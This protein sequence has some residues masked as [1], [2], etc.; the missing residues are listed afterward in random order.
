MVRTVVGMYDTIED[1]RETARELIDRGFRADRISILAHHVGAARAAGAGGSV[2]VSAPSGALRD[3][4]RLVGR[5]QSASITDIGDVMVM[6][7]LGSRITGLGGGANLRTLTDALMEAGVSSEEAPLYAEGLRRG[8]TILAA[9]VP[10]DKAY[11]AARIMDAHHPANIRVRAGHWRTEGW[12]PGSTVS[13]AAMSGPAMGAAAMGGGVTDETVSGVRREVEMP[14]MGQPPATSALR[15][16]VRGERPE[17]TPAWREE[18]VTPAAP[19][20]RPGP[21]KAPASTPSML[22]R[23]TEVEG[24]AGEVE[25]TSTTA[26]ESEAER[27]ASRVSDEDARHLEAYRAHYQRTYAGRGAEFSRYL[28]A[29]QWGYAL[30]RAEGWR[31]RNWDDVVSSVRRH[32]EERNPN[33]WDEYQA[34]IR[35]GWDEARGRARQMGV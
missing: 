30:A 1:A 35:Q 15:E 13:G 26:G 14:S 23:T 33:T 29:Y 6:G 2:D 27:L 7:P 16:E 20:E 5:M 11:D 25:P 22:Q 8:G 32:W 34:A 9:D 21:V 28:P 4:E 18:D 12:T 17:G 24:P 10:D 3:M 31:D 19:A